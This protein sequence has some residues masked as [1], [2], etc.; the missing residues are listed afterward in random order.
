[1]TVVAMGT[2]RSPGMEPCVGTARRC[3][4]LFWW[5][6]A[7]QETPEPRL[8]PQWRTRD[9]ASA[10]SL[11]KG[12]T[13]RAQSLGCLNPPGPELSHA[14]AFSLPRNG[15]LDGF[16]DPIPFFPIWKSG[17]QGEAFPFPV[18]LE[19]WTGSRNVGEHL[20]P[21]RNSLLQCTT[22]TIDLRFMK[23]KQYVPVSVP[24]VCLPMVQCSPFQPSRHSH[25]PS[26]QV[27]CSMQRG[28]HTR[29]SQAA[30]V[31][32]SSQRQAPPMQMP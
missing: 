28:W 21:W 19:R 26:L 8:L 15:N 13:G 31:Q 24:A 4:N 2:I 32:P 16:S 1:M 22:I 12:E 17:K 7:T 23:I 25:L 20:C 5:D 3:S 29:W 27:P 9:P 14:C 6:V 30:P 10:G 18:P 11:P